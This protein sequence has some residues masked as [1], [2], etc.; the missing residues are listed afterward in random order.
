M[1]DKLMRW[2]DPP[3]GWRYG[4][5]KQIDLLELGFEQEKALEKWLVKNGYP[6]E[7]AEFGA[8]HC[9]MWCVEDK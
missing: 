2:I 9:R 1:S 3:S 7:D 8:K 4:F 6:E 5:P